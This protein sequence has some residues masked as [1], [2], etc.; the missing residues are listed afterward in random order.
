MTVLFWTLVDQSSSIFFDYIG[1]CRSLKRRSPI[2]KVKFAIKL[3]VVENASTIPRSVSQFHRRTDGQTE[4]QTDRKLGRRST[5]PLAEMSG[6]VSV[7]DYSM[8]AVQW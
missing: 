1:P 7:C 5:R 3:K 4:R 6:Y 2:S 8:H